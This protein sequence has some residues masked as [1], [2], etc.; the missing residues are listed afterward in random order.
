V[1]NN[2][3]GGFIFSDNRFRNPVYDVVNVD[4]GAAA[5]LVGGF[6][7]LDLQQNNRL[8]KITY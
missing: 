6:G 3:I 4:N 2:T 1:N 5:I 7:S 8:V